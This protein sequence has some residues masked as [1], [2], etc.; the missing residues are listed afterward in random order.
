MKIYDRSDQPLQQ[1]QKINTTKQKY[2]RNIRS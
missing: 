2:I 1:Q